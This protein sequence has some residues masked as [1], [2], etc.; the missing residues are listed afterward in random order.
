MCNG[1][2]K[3]IVSMSFQAVK[4]QKTEGYEVKWP[5]KP[6]SRASS[7]HLTDHFNGHFNELT[8]LQ[9]YGSL[10]P[11]R[12]GAYPLRSSQLSW[13]SYVLETDIKET[14]LFGSLVTQ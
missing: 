4:I 10:A 11:A 12:P 8:G 5:D 1:K 14:W 6:G 13:S 3:C 2:K 9:R 7:D